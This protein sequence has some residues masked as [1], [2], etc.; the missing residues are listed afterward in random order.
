MQ[1]KRC[2]GIER[3]IRTD[4]D[5]V[6]VG[7]V[8]KHDDAIDHAVSKR[9]QR[10]DRAGLQAVKKLSDYQRHKPHTFPSSCPVNIRWLMSASRR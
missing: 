4:H 2:H 1:M 8:Q 5:D 6:A 10:K 9:D 3:C 7:E